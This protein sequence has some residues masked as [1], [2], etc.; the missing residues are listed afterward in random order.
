MSAPIKHIKAKLT[1]KPLNVQNC[2][3]LII[4]LVLYQYF[5][6]LNILPNYKNPN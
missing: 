3:V 4:V 5:N 6:K 1:I 2:H